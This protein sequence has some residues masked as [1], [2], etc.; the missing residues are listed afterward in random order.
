MS[1]VNF[2][3]SSDDWKLRGECN[4][5]DPDDFIAGPAE[6]YPAMMQAREACLVCEVFKECSQSF[7]G[8]DELYALK[9]GRLPDHQ[10]ELKAGRPP[11]DARTI[12]KRGMLAAGKCAKGHKIEGPED[13]VKSQ[14]LACRKERLEG[15][16]KTCT[17]GHESTPENTG[18]RTRKGV[19][20][21]YCRACGRERNR[22]WREKKRATLAA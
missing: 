3:P 16:M 17:R 14:C 21:L 19:P 13:I 6:H 18:T 20:E 4:W 8:D 22:E 1:A 15:G 12:R 11:K 7:E 9:A 10:A 5:L 2:A